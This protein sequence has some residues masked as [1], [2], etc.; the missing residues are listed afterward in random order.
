MTGTPAGVGLGCEPKEFLRDG[1]EFAVEVSP[2]VGTLFNVI[3]NVKK[4]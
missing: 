3:K 2:R 4:Y 1:D